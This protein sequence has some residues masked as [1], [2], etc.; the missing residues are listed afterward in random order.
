MFRHIRKHPMGWAFGTLMAIVFALMVTTNTLPWTQ[1]QPS[2]ARTPGTASGSHD[3]TRDERENTCDQQRP[4]EPI[5]VAARHEFKVSLPGLQPTIVTVAVDRDNNFA[6]AYL[7]PRDGRGWQN[8]NKCAVLMLKLEGPRSMQLVC[9]V[10]D[11]GCTFSYYSLPWTSV[12]F[13]VRGG[14]QLR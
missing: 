8:P 6:G 5:N 1:T 13:Y 3:D 4:H 9:N 12:V 7:G 2:P 11:N 10:G 14:E